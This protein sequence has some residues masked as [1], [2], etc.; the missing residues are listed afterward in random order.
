MPRNMTTAEKNAAL[1]IKAN[2]LAAKVSLRAA[3]DGLTTVGN[4]AHSASQFEIEAGAMAMRAGAL[5]ALGELDEKHSGVMLDMVA[6]FTDAID[7]L[8][9]GAGR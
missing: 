4:T 2:I 1:A 9:G 6:Q 8:G 3:V 5:K 7:V